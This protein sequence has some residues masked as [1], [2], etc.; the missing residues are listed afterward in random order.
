MTTIS[1]WFGPAKK[2]PANAS[3]EAE[4]PV[5]ACKPQTCAIQE[6]LSG[7]DYQEAKCLKEIR[8]LVACCART[9]EAAPGRPVPVQ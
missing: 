9:V 7:N 1:S 5:T 2:G 4:E 8:A 3:P 6:C